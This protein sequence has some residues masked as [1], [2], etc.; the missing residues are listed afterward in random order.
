M[1]RIWISLAALVAVGVMA[2]EKEAQSGTPA[3]LEAINGRQ[4]PVFLQS[5]EDGE[6]TFQPR[7]S[8]RNMTVSGTKI[9]SLTFFPKYDAEAVEQQIN[10]GDYEGALATLVPLMAPYV[11]YMVVENNMRGPF[12]MLMDAY[13]KS[14]DFTKAREAAN[15]LLKS[16]DPEMVHRGQ[17]TVALLAIAENDL[18]TAKKIR[19]EV[20]SET[21]GLYLQASIERV[22]QGPK[23]AIW[24]VTGIILNHANDVEWLGPS[25]LLCANLYKDMLGTNSVITT[26]SPMLTARQV[27]NMYNGSSVAADAEKLWRSLGGEEVEAAILAQKEE[28]ERLEAEIIAKRRAE[29]DKREAEEK[30]KKEAEAALKVEHEAGT[31]VNAT[32]EMDEAGTNVN[33]TVEMDEAGT[34]LNTTTEMESE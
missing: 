5:M 1:K 28:E 27:K 21:A 34:N 32:V 12:C 15:I 14:G 19:N 4:A 30:A 6:L 13:R 9:A 23:V 11:D 10:T 16:G 26:N 29:Q 31:N 24:T 17:V 2:Q 18:E 3:L 7:N 33:V 22:E 25:E 8:T 20:T